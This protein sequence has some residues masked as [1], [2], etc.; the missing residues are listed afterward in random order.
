MAQKSE[1]IDKSE[2]RRYFPDF[3]KKLDIDHS[4]VCYWFCIP[5]D[6]SLREGKTTPKQWQEYYAHEAK[7]LNF[8]RQNSQSFTTNFA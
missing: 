2:I 5:M 3:V 1:M 7:N 8:L 6:D 4:K